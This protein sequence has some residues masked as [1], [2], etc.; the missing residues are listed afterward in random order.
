MA[1][2]ALSP[3]DSTLLPFADARSGSVRQANELCDQLLTHML[4][5]DLCLDPEQPA[6]AVCMSLQSEI[7]AQG[8]V[9]TGVVFAF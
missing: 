7:K 4:D 6:C 9:G 8:G 2:A 1:S 5:C 3:I